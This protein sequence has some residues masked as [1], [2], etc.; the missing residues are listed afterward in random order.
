MARAVLAAVLVG[1]LALTGHAQN[2]VYL[3][4]VSRS[5][6]QQ[7]ELVQMLAKVHAVL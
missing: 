2:V 4:K 5:D 1:A 7:T 3:E 6:E